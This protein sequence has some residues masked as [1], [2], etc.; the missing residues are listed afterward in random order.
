MLAI[1]LQE[2]HDC[3]NTGAGMKNSL[4]I[5]DLERSTQRLEL[6]EML[7]MARHLFLNPRLRDGKYVRNNGFG[8]FNQI[9]K[10]HSNRLAITGCRKISD[11]PI[12][13]TGCVSNNRFS[14]FNQPG[15]ETAQQNV[16]NNGLH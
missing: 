3:S 14:L 4:A 12:G 9:G 11:H 1:T 6:N 13:I 8:G 7:E 5:M 2:F 15:W 10:R 16:S